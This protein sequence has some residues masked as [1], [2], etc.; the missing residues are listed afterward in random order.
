MELLK[1]LKAGQKVWKM[2][3]YL[4]SALHPTYDEAIS[5]GIISEEI[6][7]SVTT[8]EEPAN[9]GTLITSTVKLKGSDSK[10]NGFS[11]AEQREDFWG[12]IRIFDNHDAMMRVLFKLR[13]VKK[14]I[15]HLI[16]QLI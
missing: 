13:H 7:E 15:C 9:P 3:L 4:F 1:E 12:C 11:G 8:I 2:N 10:F 16:S 14:V 6:I 5:K